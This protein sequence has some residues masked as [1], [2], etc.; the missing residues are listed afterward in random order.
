MLKLYK[1]GI[2][3]LKTYPLHPKLQT[4]GKKTLI[5]IYYKEDQ[6][7]SFSD[8]LKRQLEKLQVKIEHHLK[9]IDGQDTASTSSGSRIGNY[10]SKVMSVKQ[11]LLEDVVD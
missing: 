6:M 4:D 10:E 1:E 2:A 7:N 11:V 5:D 9:K 8:S 3:N